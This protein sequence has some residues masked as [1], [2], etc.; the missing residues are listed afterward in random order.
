MAEREDP[1]ARRDRLE[2]M[3]SDPAL[4]EARRCPFCGQRILGLVPANRGPIIPRESWRVFCSTCFAYGPI[5][6]TPQGAVSYWNGNPE[7]RLPRSS[8]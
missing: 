2:K 5:C 8:A 4:H 7:G 6:D 3:Y 1:Q